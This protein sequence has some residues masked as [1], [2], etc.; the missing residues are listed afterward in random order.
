[1]VGLVDTLL[2]QH[3]AGRRVTDAIMRYAP[4]ARSDEDDRHRLVSAMQSFVTMYRP[5]AAREDTDLFP[6]LRGLVSAHEYDAMAE[7]FEM[8]ER[9]HFGPE[10]FE[11]IVD[12]VANLE[13]AI[14]INDL[15]QFTPRGL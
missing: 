12:R 3:Q 2:A 14:G 5:H 7:Q 9:R 6:K 1:M 13:K 11:K 15:N 4:N 10:G 8:E